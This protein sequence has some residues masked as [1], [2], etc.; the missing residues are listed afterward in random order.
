MLLFCVEVLQALEEGGGGDNT[1][2]LFVADH[3]EHN[4]EN[5]FLMDCYA[6]RPSSH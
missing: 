1:Y 6:A 2:V 4:L 5:R 3:G